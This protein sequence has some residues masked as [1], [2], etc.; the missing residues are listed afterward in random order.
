M[1][2]FVGGDQSTFKVE[3]S[4]SVKGTALGPNDEADIKM[5]EYFWQ[6]SVSE[7]L[8][9][10]IGQGMEIMHFNEFDYSPYDCF[11]NLEKLDDQKFQYRHNGVVPPHVFSLLARKK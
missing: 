3:V 5:M 4:A 11:P 8:N 7:I 10:L 6:H 2:M 1:A 9:A